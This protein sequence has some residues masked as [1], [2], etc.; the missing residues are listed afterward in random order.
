VRAFKAAGCDVYSADRKV[1][2]AGAT[3]SVIPVDDATGLVAGMGIN[4]QLDDGRWMPVL[5]A[6]ISSNDIIPVMQLPSAP[7]ENNIVGKA[8][9]IV[10]GKQDQVPDDQLLTQI[11]ADKSDHTR[12]DSCATTGVGEITFERDAKMMMEFTFGAANKEPIDTPM[13][14]TNTF[15]DALGGLRVHNP[16][17]QYADT[18]ASYAAAVAA[19]YQ[20]LLSGSINLNI[21]SEQVPGF[22]DPNCI[23]NMQAWM[24]VGTPPEVA[25]EL[26]YDNERIADFDGDN[27][28]KYI[29]MIQPGNSE[30]DP[31]IG[32]FMVNSHQSTKP[33]KVPYGNAQ[34]QVTTNYTSNPSTIAGTTS[35]DLG[36]QPWVLVIADRSE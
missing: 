36:Q 19:T 1:V 18:P 9:T 28:S 35:S 3:V 8:F 10:P 22:G 27:T 16:F 17:C 21:K 26:L 12:Y 15:N 23:N 6:S 20:K 4:V 24:Q 2:Q 32:F 25:I 5:I 14:G 13:D 33:E 34:H 31:A 30:S 7:S 11:H 29:S